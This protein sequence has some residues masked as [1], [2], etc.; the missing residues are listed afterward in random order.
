MIQN[1]PNAAPETGEMLREI[2]V[3]HL[4]L[5]ASPCG[6]QPRSACDLDGVLEGDE[7]F[8]SKAHP[9]Q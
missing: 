8:S 2:I 5:A 7:S 1:V 9:P 6:R 3:S 4:P